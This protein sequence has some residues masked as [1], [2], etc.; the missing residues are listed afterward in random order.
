MDNDD[1]NENIPEEFLDSGA[2]SSRRKSLKEYRIK[3][4]RNFES[5]HFARIWIIEIPD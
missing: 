4:V 5:G 3:A 1:V 2:A